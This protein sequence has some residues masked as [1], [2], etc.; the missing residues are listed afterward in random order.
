MKLFAL[1]HHLA[2]GF[3][4]RVREALFKLNE[5]FSLGGEGNRGTLSPR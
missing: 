4:A 3:I 1:E 5:E 2:S